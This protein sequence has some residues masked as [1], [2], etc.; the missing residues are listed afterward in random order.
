[1]FGFNNTY[2]NKQNQDALFNTDGSAGGGGSD[3][4]I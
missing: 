2:I 4:I 3:D 1:M